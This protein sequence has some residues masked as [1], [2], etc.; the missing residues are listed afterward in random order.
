MPPKR[1]APSAKR[2]ASTPSSDAYST[3][4]RSRGVWWPKDAIAT[5]SE[6]VVA[7]V[8]CVATSNLKKNTVICRVPRAACLGHRTAESD[9]N[10]AAADADERPIEGD[11]HCGLAL[12][13]LNREKNEAFAPLLDILTPA[14]CPWVWPAE[15][16]R[17]LDGTELEPVLK[18]KNRRLELEFDG[19]G[20][21]PANERPDFVSVGT[22]ERACALAASHV[23][24]WFGGAVVPF[25]CTL[26]W[27]ADPN[28]EFDAEGTEWVV[29][30]T[31]RDVKKG[32]E[33]FQECAPTTAEL[34]YR[35]GFAPPPL[36]TDG[37]SSR[38]RKAAQDDDGGSSAST[39]WQV[40]PED[41]VS[42]RLE[43]IAGGKSSRLSDRTAVLCLAGAVASS[44]WD[45]L[46]DTYTVEL[47]RDGGGCAKLIGVCLA[48]AADDETWVKAKKAAEEAAE[49]VKQA[50]AQEEEGEDDDES[51]DGADDAAAAAL[52]AALLDITGE[53]AVALGELA[54]AEGGE[55]GDPWPA[56]L[57]Q[58]AE[59]SHGASREAMDAAADAALDAVR[60]R[61]AA[62]DDARA[63][64]PAQ[65]PDD[66]LM[67]SAWQAA[68]GLRGVER[69]ILQQ[70]GDWLGQWR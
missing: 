46:T 35:Y 64:P 22:F 61:R 65:P 41:A 50:A 62:L 9:L 17:W 54:A 1:L 2:R 26:N 28:V 27:S 53:D 58:A 5:T 38:K 32:E 63:P 40:L 24:P 49:G 51:T 11:S 15:A 10:G 19:I 13:L 3:W 4:L 56:I 34:V 57:A 39:V 37:G 16:A 47:T 29:G 20:M 60:R 48:L 43:D 42:I 70:A 31:T 30:K 44:P 69:T 18:R 66:D 12:E 6:G 67:Q 45:G 33:L 7:G 23:N 59:E 52:V 14:A 68:V 36:S 55:E 25:N 21:I 8:G